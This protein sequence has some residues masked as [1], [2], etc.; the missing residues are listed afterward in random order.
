MDGARTHHP[1][2]PTPHSLDGCHPKPDP[3]WIRKGVSSPCPTTRRRPAR[4]WSA[5]RAASPSSRT[6]PICASVSPSPSRPS[7]RHAARPRRRWTRSCARWTARASP[8]PTSGRRCCRSSHATTTVMD[9]RRSSP[10]T[11]S[12]TSSRC[13]FAIC[14]SSATSSMR[15]LPPGPPAWTPSPS[16][17]PTPSR[18]SATRAVRRWPRRGHGPM[19]W[20]KQPA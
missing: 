19:S 9:G 14:P 12:R 20:P 2:G 3:S 7:R 15:R 16:D 17:S 18:Q 5:A 8:E 10:A 13:P 4:S 6:S 1:L 11:R